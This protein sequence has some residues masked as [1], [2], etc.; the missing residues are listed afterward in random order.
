[1]GDLYASDTPCGELWGEARPCA[2]RWAGDGDGIVVVASLSL[3][4]TKMRVS[5]HQ[6]SLHASSSKS[7]AL[8]TSNV[9]L[10]IT[11]CGHVI[12]IK[13]LHLLRTKT[14][15]TFAAWRILTH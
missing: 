3:I 11:Y 2:E 1:M 14:A 5:L 10:V 12:G 13:T 15:P 9:P 4:E 8:F 6:S 7:K